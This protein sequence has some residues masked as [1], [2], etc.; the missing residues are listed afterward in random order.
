ME[1]TQITVRLPKL[2]LS[3]FDRHCNGLEFYSRSHGFTV[4]LEKWLE[5]TKKENKGKQLNLHEMPGPR[6]GKNR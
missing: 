6:K 4:I 5:E 2:L 1:R 3:E